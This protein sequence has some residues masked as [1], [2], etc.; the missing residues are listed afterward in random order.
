MGIEVFIYTVITSVAFMLISLLMIY[1]ADYM[2]TH[3]MSKRKHTIDNVRKLNAWR[4][5]K[6]SFEILALVTGAIALLSTVGM[7][8]TPEDTPEMQYE[9][10]VKAV[11]KSQ[12]ALDR[13]LEKHPEFV[14]E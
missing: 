14:E 8:F 6:E 3:I 13:F 4:S 9:N 1:L 7:I 10:H 5:I 12:Q 11:K 2:C